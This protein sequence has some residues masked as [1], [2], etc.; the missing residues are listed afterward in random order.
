MLQRLA[1]TCFFLALTSAAIPAPAADRLPFRVEHVA[2]FDEPWSMAFL[3]GGRLLVTEK[4]G[5]LLIVDADG[6]TSR[7]LGGVPDVDY[8]GQGG[9]GDVLVHPD[10]ERNGSSTSAMPRPVRAVRAARRWPGRCCT[11]RGAART[12]KTSR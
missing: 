12:S 6:T 4:K 1:A 9:L 10:F 2:T 3:P 7:P 5:N 11:P 8:G